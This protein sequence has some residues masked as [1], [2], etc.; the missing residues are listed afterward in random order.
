MNAPLGARGTAVR[1]GRRR[2]ETVACLVIGILV[3][4]Y[5]VWSALQ[6]ANSRPVLTEQP[7]GYYSLQTAGFRSGHLYSAAVPDPALLRLRDPYD[8]SANTPFRVHDMSLFK[9]HYY[10]YYGITPLL[11]LFWPVAVIT[12]QYLSEPLAVGIFCS[13]AVWTGMGLLLAIRRRHF[14]AAPSTSLLMGWLCL[15][16][17]TP[18]G[19]LVENPRVYEV[20][21]SCAIFLQ[22][23]M[24]VAVY[25]ALHSPLRALQ[26]MVA[27]GLLFGLSVGARPNH[28]AGAIVLLVPVV[29]RCAPQGDRRAWRTGSL[30]AGLLCTF[31]P[32]AACGA[33]LLF[34]NWARFGSVFE[35]GMHYQLA[36]E[37]VS[38][39]KA[40]SPEY[41]LPHVA[42]YL[43]SPGHWDSYFPFFSSAHGQPFGFFRYLPWSWL[44]V[45]A[46]LWPGQGSS[47]ERAGRGA[48]EVALGLA[49]TGNLA[50]LA[51]FFGTTYRYPAD[52]ANAG[53]MLAGVGAMALGQRASA[54]GHGNKVGLAL[55]AS[56]AGSL[57]VSAALFTGS[58][59]V[60]DFFSRRRPGRQLARVC[61]AKGQE[62]RLRRSAD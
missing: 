52:F 4:W 32:A 20:P 37:R 47:A 14:P 61:L 25:R 31:V 13:A 18:L 42:L 51:C 57:F 54:A 55:A 12:G 1:F 21:I 3:G 8:P 24:L 43:F 17:A 10:L 22:A 50:L 41:L 60:D 7:K 35:F 58:F 28:L 30:A 39:L 19:L 49:F 40:M 46:F 53:L 27:S 26:W 45:A 62:H 44:I 34:Y 6:T 38:Q 29:Y 36:A 23:L 2:V 5:Y 16:W 48:I 9:G 15:A 11:I 56:A 33:G 59:P